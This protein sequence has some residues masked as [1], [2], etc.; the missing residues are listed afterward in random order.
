MKNRFDRGFEETKQ[1]KVPKYGIR[2]LKVGVVSCLL[3]F[4]MF[5]PA[6]GAHAEGVGPV[7]VDLNTKKKAEADKLYDEV[8]KKLKDIAT[9]ISDELYGIEQLEAN[10]AQAQADADAAQKAEENAKKDLVQKRADYEVK[11]KEYAEAE[12]K[13]KQRKA[14]EKV[15]KKKQEKAAEKHTDAENKLKTAENDLNNLAEAPVTE[16]D[17]NAVTTATQ[18]VTDKTKALKDLEG[19]NDIYNRYKKERKVTAK[20]Q[21]KSNDDIVIA[22]LKEEDDVKNAIKAAQDAIKYKDDAST[23]K[24]AEEAIKQFKKDFAEYKANNTGDNDSD[25]E[26]ISAGEHAGE[27]K[28]KD[29]S[30]DA[31]KN[32][33]KL[34]ADITAINEC[35]I[36][37][38]K[39]ITFDSD[40]DGIKQAKA[41]KLGDAKQKAFN[42]LPANESDTTTARKELNEAK[43]ELAKA[44]HVIDA[45]GLKKDSAEKRRDKAE[46]KENDAQDALDNAT[47]ALE[48]AEDNL[49]AATNNYV[50]A[51]A[52]K[53][54]AC[55]AK[56]TAHATLKTAHIGF[57]NAKESLRLTIKVAKTG[58][59]TKKAPEKGKEKDEKPEEKAERLGIEGLRKE[60]A[61]QLQKAEDEYRKV[62]LVV[63][64]KKDRIKLL[65]D[66]I[67]STK[68]FAAMASNTDAAES[69]DEVI[70]KYNDEIEGL[71]DEV[72]DYSEK[73]AESTA[74]ITAIRQLAEKAKVLKPR[75]LK[76]EGWSQEGTDWT[77]TD[78]NGMT[79]KDN[80]VQG[81]N[82]DWFYLDGFGKMAHDKWVEVN[83]KWFYAGSN[84][85]IA[86]EQWIQ[87]KL[88]DWFYVKK[89][90]YMAQNEWVQVKGQWY[91]A[92]K[93]GNMAKNVTLNVNGV[94][95]SFNANCAWVK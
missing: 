95:Y 3:A 68:K 88:G 20:E 93:D 21:L 8:N 22:K 40:I 19:K 46:Q 81:K 78:S 42:D 11:K 35:I 10:I 37:A 43:E 90:G 39:A 16:E 91:Y 52:A 66:V 79:V 62:E 89:G 86:Q 54:S 58:D 32:D 72:A 25:L 73:L 29:N 87:N 18:K 63:T 24:K 41:N 14:E 33:D 74:L 26:C 64:S 1:N 75:N 44:Q 13:L 53:E 5:A 80:W 27:A 30:K 61:K 2:K 94:N 47:D 92:Q 6:V 76:P 12:A 50:L 65:Q 82:G 55:D 84:G 60:V 77:Y 69:F 45:K 9:E 15:A 48:T 85:V 28:W 83:K 49:S 70:D 17:N 23:C 7:H 57:R 4:S 56:N 34:N 38:K 67:A 51:K 59:T 71:S 36:A 31:A